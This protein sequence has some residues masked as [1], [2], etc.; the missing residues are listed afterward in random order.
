MYKQAEIDPND[1]VYVEAHGTGTKVGDPK[2]ANA[3]CDIFCSE[4]EEALLIG[5]VK[6]M[7]GHA[8]PAAAIASLCKVRCTI[9]KNI[10]L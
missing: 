4:R 9:L 5:S 3:I 1:V 10:I 2:E 6:S 7:M 8:E